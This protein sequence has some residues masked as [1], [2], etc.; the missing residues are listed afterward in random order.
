ISPNCRPPYA[1]P[2]LPTPPA[3]SPS[4][5]PPTTRRWPP[6]S[7]RPTSTPPTYKAS[8]TTN[9]SR[10]WR[11]G[12]GWPLP[13]P[14]SRCR[15]RHR[16]AWLTPSAP[17]PA[18]AWAKP[19]PPWKPPCASVPNT[20]ARG[21]WAAGGRHEPG[22]PYYAPRGEHCAAGPSWGRS[23]GRKCQRR[24][25]CRTASTPSG[26]L[27]HRRPPSGARS[28]VVRPRTV[29]TD[30]SSTSARDDGRATPALALCRRLAA[31]TPAGARAH[32]GAAAGGAVAPTRRRRT[33]RIGRGAR[34]GRCR[35]ANAPGGSRARRIPAAA[36]LRD[37][38]AVLAAVLGPWWRIGNLEAG[39]PA[40]PRRRPIRG[41]VVDRVRP[42]DAVAAHHRPQGRAVSPLLD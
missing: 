24:D 18:P 13:R 4:A 40:A 39:C 3:G 26:T 15:C 14:A 29:G 16:P 32:G 23:S 5:Y 12:T 36:G 2:F 11:W 37:G 31:R 27:P 17:A 8:G 19:P 22:A 35:G 25:R 7:W 42:L 30:H 1:R 21:R 38:A 6:A 20:P 10:A 28:A 9:A 41:L 33:R 34:L